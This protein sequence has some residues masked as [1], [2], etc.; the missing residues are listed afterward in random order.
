MRR[1]LGCNKNISA[2]I[3]YC[4][5]CGHRQSRRSN[6]LPAVIVLALLAVLGTGG[7]I[8]VTLS[9]FFSSPS[10]ST[11]LPVG[12]T[13]AGSTPVV[14]SPPTVI[15]E[16]TEP[17]D[18][19]Q[20]QAVRL[21]DTAAREATAEAEQVTPTVWVVPSST[22]IPPPTPTPQLPPFP[23]KELNSILQSAGG[24]F[25]VAMYDLT[26]DQTVYEQ[27]AEQSFSAAGLINLPIVITVYALAQQGQLDLN[28][29]LTMQPGDIVGGTGVLQTHAPGTIYTIRELCAFMLTVS[30]NTA[31][32]MVLRHIGGFDVVNAR[33][34]TLGARQTRV[35]RFLMDLESRQAGFDNWTSPGDMLLLLQQVELG[36]SIGEMGKQE[37][38]AA[39]AYSSDRNKIPARLPPGAKI[40][41]RTGTLPAPDSAEHD[42]ALIELPSGRQYI[43][44]IMGKYVRNNQAGVQAIAEASRLIFDYANQLDN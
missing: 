11:T 23:A 30:D 44:V 35:E 43:V 25:G 8:A 19:S 33:M 1:C 32:N 31:T 42:I 40:R 12:D 6:W 13:S 38:L 20:E 34:D 26:S 18:G 2:E 4:P 3:A 16:Q 14:A 17:P 28:E 37:I 39:M 29:Q 15:K 9:S 7:G 22:P 24:V 5:Y 21:T 27:N 10:S 36:T 41:N